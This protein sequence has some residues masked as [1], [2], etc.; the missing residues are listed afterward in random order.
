MSKDNVTERYVAIKTKKAD[1]PESIIPVEEKEEVVADLE[2]VTSEPPQEEPQNE[3]DE[4]GVEVDLE[5]GEIVEEKED[6][7]KKKSK[8]KEE[9]EKKIVTGKHL[10][11]QLLLLPF[12]QQE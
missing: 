5:T 1:K 9:I 11:S 2:D 8:K 10:L 3:D 12:P 6:K 7:P 4:K